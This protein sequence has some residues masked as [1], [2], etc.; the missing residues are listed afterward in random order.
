M[1]TK[2][3]RFAEAL[4]SRSPDN[5]LIDFFNDV[6]DES[7]N[8]ERYIAELELVQLG[9]EILS[10]TT[11]EILAQSARIRKGAANNLREFRRI[12]V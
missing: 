4:Q 6:Y 11:I 5:A 10:V 8:N 9:H 2:L 1:V 7:E 12:R 3:D